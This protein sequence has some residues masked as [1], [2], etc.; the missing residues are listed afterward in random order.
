MRRLILHR[1]RNLGV[2]GVKGL[3]TKGPFVSRDKKKETTEEP[4]TTT[5]KEGPKK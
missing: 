2:T 5:P 3:F 1:T 4:A